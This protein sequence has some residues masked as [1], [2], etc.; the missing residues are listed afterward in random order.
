MYVSVLVFLSLFFPVIAFYSFVRQKRRKQAGREVST[1]AAEKRAAQI[2]L[3]CAVEITTKR[4]WC[5][6]RASFN[7]SDFSRSYSP[8]LHRYTLSFADASGDLLFEE[9][10]SLTDFFGFCWYPGQRKKPDRNSMYLCDAVLLEFIPPGPGEYILSFELN[11][12]EQNS[13]L[14]NVTL[15]VREGVWPLKKKPFVHTCADLRKHQSDE[16]VDGIAG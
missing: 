4:K 3:S 6:I 9:E 12:R 7:R 8:G 14:E 10:R 2:A 5:R 1:V 13:H 11:A 16:I 15:F